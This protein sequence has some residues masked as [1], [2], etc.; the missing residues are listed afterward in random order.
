MSGKTSKTKERASPATDA[1]AKRRLTFWSDGFSIDHV[2]S[3]SGQQHG[4]L[5]SYSENRSFLEAVQRGYVPMSLYAH[6]V[7]VL[8]LGWHR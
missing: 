6:S 2:D 1:V 5:L 8:L 3:G 7:L 4:P